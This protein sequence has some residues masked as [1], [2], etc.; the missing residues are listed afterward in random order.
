MGV[1]KR[2]CH[3]RRKI[4][5]KIKL[6]RELNHKSSHAGRWCPREV[7]KAGVWFSSAKGESWKM[8]TEQPAH[9]HLSG[10]F[11]ACF[12]LLKEEP[13]TRWAGAITPTMLT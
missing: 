9:K 6:L 13:S 7:V 5:Y 3:H 1:K 2:L 11:A 10:L 12:P 8:E 4:P